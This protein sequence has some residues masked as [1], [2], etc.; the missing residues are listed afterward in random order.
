MAPVLRRLTAH[1]TGAAMELRPASNGLASWR[2]H[3]CHSQP[4]L[5]RHPAPIASKRTFLFQRQTVPSSALSRCEPHRHRALP[6]ASL[7][8]PLRARLAP[9]QTL[10]CAGKNRISTRP[11]LPS[12]KVESPPQLRFRPDFSAAALCPHP[13]AALRPFWQVELLPATRSDVRKSKSSPPFDC[14]SL[15]SDPT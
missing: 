10:R 5:A 2:E 12:R 1:R 13:F 14:I 11:L 3:P 8:Q 15:G 6:L 4:R 7:R 9:F